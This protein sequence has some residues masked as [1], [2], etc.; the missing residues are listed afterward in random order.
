MNVNGR[1]WDEMIAACGCA[2]VRIDPG[3][4]PRELPPLSEDEQ[5]DVEITFHNQDKMTT[6]REWLKILD[7]NPDGKNKFAHPLVLL[8]LGENCPDEQRQDPLFTIWED[9]NGN[10]WCLCLYVRDGERSLYVG[11]HGFDS[12]WMGNYWAVAVAKPV[13]GE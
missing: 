1:G 13:I 12:F 4:D 9:S 3:F 11:Y 8:A 5:G 10:F 2:K 7:K 6:D